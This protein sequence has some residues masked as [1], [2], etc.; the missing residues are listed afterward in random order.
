MLLE[1]IWRMGKMTVD[2]KYKYLGQMQKRYKK[3]GRKER[4]R[5]LDKMEAVTPLH[6]KFLIRLM[7][8]NIVRRKR[9]RQRGVVYGSEVKYVVVHVARSSN[10]PGAGRLQPQLL[11]TAKHLAR[12]G[13]IKLTSEI[14]NLFRFLNAHTQ[15]DTERGFTGCA[16]SPAGAEDTQQD[17]P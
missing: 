8:S 11:L 4:N 6:R 9:I 7:N 2:E 16:P 5:L 12:H 15:E 17:C 1:V 3:A 10:Y 14:E 13:E